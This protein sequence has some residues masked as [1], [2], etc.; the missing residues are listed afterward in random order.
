MVSSVTARGPGCVIAEEAQIITP[1]PLSLTV[2]MNNYCHY[3]VIVL[4]CCVSVLPDVA[5]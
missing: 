4:I 2:T 1:P 3:E 5:L